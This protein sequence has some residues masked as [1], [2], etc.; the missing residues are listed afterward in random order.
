MYEYSNIIFIDI[1]I[2]NSLS[3]I[4]YIKQVLLIIWTNPTSNPSRVGGLEV[5]LEG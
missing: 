3:N 5:G 2:V 1:V 4:Y